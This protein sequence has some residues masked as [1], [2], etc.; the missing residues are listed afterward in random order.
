MTKTVIEFDLIGYSQMAVR[1]QAL[2]GPEAISILNSRIQAP[3]R[4]GLMDRG[5]DWELCVKNTGGDS[6][7]LLLESA[8][9]A[10]DLAVSVH[11]W[12]AA[13]NPTNES[14]DERDALWFRVGIATGPVSEAFGGIAGAAIIDAVRLEAAGSPGHILIDEA[15]YA[16]LPERCKLKYGPA[17]SVLDKHKVARVVRRFVV[18]NVAQAAHDAT[19][20]W[21][22]QMGRTSTGTQVVPAVVFTHFGSLVRKVAESREPAATFYRGVIKRHLNCRKHVGL[23]YVYIDDALRKMLKKLRE[24]KGDRASLD[25]P[26]QILIRERELEDFLKEV[27]REARLELG[28]EDHDRP[29]IIY[30]GINNLLAFLENLYKVDPHLIDHI[31]GPELIFRFIREVCT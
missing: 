11:E 23:L 18:I 30:V 28:M 25:V 24:E 19:K 6:V 3:I 13:N 2:L 10:H 8:A 26:A 22:A 9:K 12:S 4:Q 5:L 31:A 7:V 14:G 1:L 27:E 15:T 20:A 29:K 21:T 17:E 16:A